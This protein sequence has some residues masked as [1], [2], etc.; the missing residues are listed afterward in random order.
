MTDHLINQFI[1]A[2]LTFYTALKE[3]SDVF[4]FVY[5]ICSMWVIITDNHSYKF[6]DT[7]IKKKFLILNL[8]LRR[9]GQLLNFTNKWFKYVS[10]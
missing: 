8:N 6:S 9:K 1:A 10:I 3:Y 2:L 7:E 4:I 5:C